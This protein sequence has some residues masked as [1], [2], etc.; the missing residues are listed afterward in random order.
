MPCCLCQRIL[1][2]NSQLL[3]N[4]QHKKRES[5]RTHIGR[6]IHRPRQHIINTCTKW[7][8][9]RPNS[10]N[11]VNSSSIFSSRTFPPA[12]SIH[13]QRKSNPYAKN[14][15]QKQNLTTAATD[16][17][18][19][20]APPRIYNPPQKQKKQKQNVLGLWH[21]RTWRGC[22]RWHSR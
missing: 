15:L 4:L 5:Y 1:T 9:T 12:A 6:I 14:R 13:I 11:G 19:V 8:S 2:T 17:K 18:D 10:W 21:P 20:P 3:R 16:R 7:N 22:W